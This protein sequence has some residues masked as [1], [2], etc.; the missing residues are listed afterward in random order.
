MS[1]TVLIVDDEID[2][3]RLVR[4]NLEKEGFHVLTAYDGMATFTQI[5]DRQPD[6]LILDLM[7]PDMSGFKICQQIKAQPATKNIPVIMLTARSSEGDRVAGFEAGA[8]DYVVKPFSPKELVLRVKALLSRTRASRPAAESRQIDLGGVIVQPDA[9][10]IETAQGESIALSSLEFK[11][12]L[13]LVTHPNM[14]RTR[15]Q[16]IAEVWEQEGENISDRT[17]DTHIKR[18]RQ[19]LGDARDVIETI[20]GVGYRAVI[21]KTTATAAG[22][23]A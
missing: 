17:V 18:L 10:T 15:E 22:Q 13:S 3:V 2:L 16:L 11:L 12:L 9:H 1:A 19:K 23:I 7:L 21:R 5:R 4:Y 6:L 8:D 20:R 14:V